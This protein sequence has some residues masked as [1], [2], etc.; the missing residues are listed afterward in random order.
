[1][2][3]I[4]KQ[5][6]LD[7]LSSVSMFHAFL[8]FFLACFRMMKILL[9]FPAAFFPLLLVFRTYVFLLSFLFLFFSLQAAAS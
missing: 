4:S 7:C 1:M 6:L 9:F 2:Q 5:I 8:I 3:R